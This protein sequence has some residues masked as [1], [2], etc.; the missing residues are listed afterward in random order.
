MATGRR[1][2]IAGTVGTGG[3]TLNFHESVAADFG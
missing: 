3:R 2:A 1:V